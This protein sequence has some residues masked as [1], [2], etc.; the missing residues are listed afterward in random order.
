[1]IPGGGGEQPAE[2]AA[3]Q[4][5]DYCDDRVLGVGRRRSANVVV[6]G[7]RFSGWAGL[8]H[9]PDLDGLRRNKEGLVAGG[10]FNLGA[11]PL[12]FALEML[13]AM[14]AAEL[15]LEE[16]HGRGLVWGALGG[17]SCTGSLQ[18]FA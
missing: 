3:E 18:T 2:E 8:G 6:R 5:G 12:A 17:S 14:G 1:M 11:G 16:D 4:G 10:A 9:G 13:P 15:V 7:R